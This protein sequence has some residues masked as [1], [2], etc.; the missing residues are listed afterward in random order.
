MMCLEA[1]EW[2]DGKTDFDLI[3]V[4]TSR[5]C[6][7]AT[8]KQVV[9]TNAFLLRHREEALYLGNDFF[10]IFSCFRNDGRC[11]DSFQS[12]IPRRAAKVFLTTS[13]QKHF[14]FPH[15]S[16]ENIIRLHFEK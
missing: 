4:F 6:E 5:V 16:D 14:T 1:G 3:L 9:L 2:L 13:S 15:A 12:F 10:C 11:C 7:A 8:E